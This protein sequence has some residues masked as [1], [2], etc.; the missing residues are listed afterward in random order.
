[1]SEHIGWRA[2]WRILKYRGMAMGKPYA[3][4]VDDGNLALHEGLNFITTK[5]CDGTGA[6]FSNAN[7][8][9]GVGDSAAAVTA[10]QTGL[11]AI[12]NKLYHAMDASY[13]TYGTN[14]QI[15]FRATF[16][17]TDAN[18]AWNERTVANGN[19]DAA[20]NLNRKVSSVGTKVSGETWIAELT[21]TLS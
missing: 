8:Y 16:G 14:Q 17:P 11:Q 7:S 13:P 2:R 18:F 3:V 20:V 5:M 10:N 4:F 9:I 19:S 15:V 6:L 21:L 12:T 1:M